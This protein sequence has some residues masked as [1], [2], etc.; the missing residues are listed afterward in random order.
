[1]LKGLIPVLR[2]LP[3]VQGHCGMMWLRHREHSGLW[4]RVSGFKSQMLLTSL[5]T[6]VKLIKL[7]KP[8]FTFK[9][10]TIIAPTARV[11]M[12]RLHLCR[13]QRKGKWQNDRYR[14]HIIA[15]TA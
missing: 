1:M 10:G 5:T 3:S 11:P 15:K 12:K 4:A 2:P 8:L 13:E 14:D 6:L 9:M 7:S